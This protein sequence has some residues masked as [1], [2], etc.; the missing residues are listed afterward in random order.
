MLAKGIRTA[1]INLVNRGTA[2]GAYRISV[3]DSEMTETGTVYTL[4]DGKRT[5]HSLQDFIRYS[6]RRT[7]MGERDNQNIR[8]LV[9]PPK[10]LPDGEYFSHLKVLMTSDNVEEDNKSQEKED[11]DDKGFRLELK[12]RSAVAIPIIY[13]HGK[14][15]VSVELANVNFDKKEKSLA[16]D[17]FRKGNIS[18]MGDLLVDYLAPSGETI[19]VSVHP[20]KAIYSNINKRIFKEPLR[21]PKGVDITGI[22]FNKGLLHIQ[23]VDHEDQKILIAETTYQL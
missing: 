22:S 18:T 10:D 12:Q 9:R 6:P 2:R 4:N 23:Y 20:G 14:T 1:N 13:Q 19:R 3:V 15:S 5:A 11:L 7:E 8:I 16:I 21:A 17:M